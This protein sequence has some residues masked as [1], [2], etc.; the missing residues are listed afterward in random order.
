MYCAFCIAHLGNW[1]AHLKGFLKSFFVNYP[2]AA[3]LSVIIWTV[4]NKNKLL[5]YDSS[6]DFYLFTSSIWSNS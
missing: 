3:K 5:N 6:L 4:H 1:Y 2:F